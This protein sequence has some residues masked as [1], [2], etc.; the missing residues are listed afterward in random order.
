M[1]GR[2][3]VTLAHNRRNFI[4]WRIISLYRLAFKTWN[5]S[6]KNVSSLDKIVNMSQIV[7]IMFDFH[8][9]EPH[10]ICLLFSCG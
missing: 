3:K 5:L 7:I 2:I 8:I 4:H 9:I 10:F 6:P 1:I